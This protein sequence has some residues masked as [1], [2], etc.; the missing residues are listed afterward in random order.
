MI[1]NDRIVRKS[2]VGIATSSRRMIILSIETFPYCNF[3]SDSARTTAG[4]LPESDWDTLAPG[5][6]NQSVLQPITYYYT[7]A[8]LGTYSAP[9]A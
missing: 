6:V 8:W 1:P 4:A 9:Q 7:H 2:I 5:A 3:V